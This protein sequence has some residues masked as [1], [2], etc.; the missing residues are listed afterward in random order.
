MAG[1]VKLPINAHIQAI[2][3]GNG[4]LIDFWHG[5]CHIT[6]VTETKTI[7]TRQRGPTEIYLSGFFLKINKG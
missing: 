1:C 3:R 4:R 6:T 5:K 2:R 7:F